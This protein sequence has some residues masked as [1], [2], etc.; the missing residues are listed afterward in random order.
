MIATY[1]EITKEQSTVPCL[2]AI[3]LFLG[4][5]FGVNK[6]K[7]RRTVM[8]TLLTKWNFLAIRCYIFE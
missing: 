8:D 6:K 2:I 1:Q 5:H 4:D 7:Q 3:L